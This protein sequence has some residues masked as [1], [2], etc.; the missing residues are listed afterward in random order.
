MR[1]RLL[2]AAAVAISVVATGCGAQTSTGSASITAAKLVGRDIAPGALGGPF[3]AASTGSAETA[4]AAS[5]IATVADESST[6][7]LVAVTGTVVMTFTEAQVRN[8]ALQAADGGGILG[9]ALDATEMMPSGSPPL[10]YLLAAW[11]SKTDTPGADAVR[12]AMGMQTWAQ[13]P[14]VVFPMIALPLFVSD[15]ITAT[16]ASSTASSSAQRV[17]IA[18][19][20]ATNLLDF[21]S[22]PCTTVSNFIQGV[23]NSVFTGLQLGTPSGTSTISKIG[24]FFV[25]LWNNALLIA[26]TVLNGLLTKL[27]DTI[28][29]AIRSVAAG[30]A[31][32]AQIVAYVTPWS[33]KITP[34]V[35]TVSAGDGG[36]ISAKVDSAGP[37][38]Y[39]SA[40]SDCAG[41]ADVTLPPL[42]GANLP[43]TWSLTGAISPSGP[44][45]VTLD[46][47]GSSTIRFT[48]TAQASAGSAACD[49][50]RGQ[51][52]G[53]FGFVSISVTR[54]GIDGLQQL[55]NGL[56]A[57]GLGPIAGP[58]VKSLLGPILASIQAQ[59]AK[60]TQS[61]IGTGF[62]VVTGQAS[63][64]GS[65]CPSP[66]AS[67]SSSATPRTLACTAWQTVA[68]A[69]NM[70]HLGQQTP[71]LSTSQTL[72]C[73][74]TPP[75]GFDIPADCPDGTSINDNM[76]CFDA[77]ITYVLGGSPSD[78]AP[79]GNLYCSTGNQCVP[80]AIAGSD[81]DGDAAEG[82]SN[83]RV[84]NT[85]YKDVD[86][87]Q[88]E[89]G[90][91]DVSVSAAVP[92]ANEEALIKTIF[93][94]YFGS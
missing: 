48:T 22:A 53:E 77:E 15:V 67:P 45:N 70:S 51:P 93:A 16:E 62:V 49:E 72:S 6:T 71:F 87:V 2:L 8:M 32:I 92:F 23:L 91:L 42:G 7:P 27:T 44:T 46:S 24:K 40:V 43:T 13:A 52:Q 18:S 39:P 58:I 79:D 61:V 20:Q 56:L 54:S 30:L 41:K 17:G 36:T 47:S 74:Y 60:L 50:A 25:T 34:Q 88:A 83:A 75:E 76:N 65:A 28:V 90:G 21:T 5:G 3:T 86:E 57:T 9:S 73:L 68:G 12:T 82:F 31:V 37:S 78:V 84:G 14:D 19:A 1:S 81:V 35:Q 11:V 63:S 59:L 85:G 4:L 69:L 38:S 80:F 55:V 33:V 94:Q 64:G 89:K 29:G 66:T 26:Q 10:S